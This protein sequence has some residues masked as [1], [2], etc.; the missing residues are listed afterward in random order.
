M[1]FWFDEN[2]SFEICAK[3]IE[4]DHCPQ[5]IKEEAEKELRKRGYPEKVITAIRLGRLEDL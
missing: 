2:D 1:G 4:D 5:S 3:H